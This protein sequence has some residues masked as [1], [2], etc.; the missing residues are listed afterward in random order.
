MEPIGEIYNS[1]GIRIYC[2][3]S[4]YNISN[5]E[6][7][8][9]VIFIENNNDY[10]V[11]IRFPDIDDFADYPTYIVIDDND[12][13]GLSWGNV[14][15]DRLRAFMQGNYEIRGVERIMITNDR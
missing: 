5:V 7:W 15:F 8:Q 11:E 10:C 13:A 14:G 6:F 1:G 2:L 3:V 12:C 9:P 4:V